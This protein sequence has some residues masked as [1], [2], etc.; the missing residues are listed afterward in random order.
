MKYTSVLLL[1]VPQILLNMCI[2]NTNK[3]VLLVLRPKILLNMYIKLICLC[4]IYFKNNRL[5]LKVISVKDSC[6]CVCVYL[7]STF[8]L[9][10]MFSC[11]ISAVKGGVECTEAMLT[12]TF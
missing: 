8:L 1:S 2:K 7:L 10:L 4:H 6:V 12:F 9:H 3:F 5:M 11:S